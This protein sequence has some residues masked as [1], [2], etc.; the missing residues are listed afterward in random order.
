MLDKPVSEC[1]F[2]FI[3]TAYQGAQG[4]MSWLVED[5]Y[6]AYSMGWKQ[7]SVL[8][9]AVKGNWNKEMWWPLIEQ[10]DVI[11]MGGGHGWYLSYWLQK[12]GLFDALPELLKTKVYVGISA[13]SM[14]ATAG[15]ASAI[16]K[17][18]APAD[19]SMLPDDV[20]VPT[21]Q[22]SDKTLGLTNFLFRPH[23]G[24]PDPKYATLNEA[25]VRQ[26]YQA[27]Q[28]PIYLVDD[29]TGIKI[30]DGELEVVSEGKWLLVDGKVS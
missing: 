9:I 3:P 22:T 14:V 30:V 11:Q 25:A 16:G 5:F 21:E 15:I 26:A 6:N 12:A 19:Y 28:K 4:D 20:R 13:G 10:A 2:L 17:P 1:N 29:E 8:D 27:L 23:W 7:F 24:K 18:N